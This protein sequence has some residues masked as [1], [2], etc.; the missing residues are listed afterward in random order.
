[1][2]VQDYNMTKVLS[3]KC[4][5]PDETGDI[6]QAKCDFNTLYNIQM[7]IELYN[8]CS[9]LFHHVRNSS[10]E[11]ILE[12][13][14]QRAA[15]KGA[16]TE[17]ETKGVNAGLSVL[18]MTD[19]PSGVIFERD[20]CDFMNNFYVD[21]SCRA[22]TNIEEIHKQTQE[23]KELLMQ[24]SAL[25]E[26]KELSSVWRDGIDRLV[27]NNYNNYDN[28]IMSKHKQLETEAENQ[29]WESLNRALSERKFGTSR[30]KS[31]TTLGFGM[32]QRNNG[33]DG[34]NEPV[35]GE[36]IYDESNRR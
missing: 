22:F 4:S 20:N 15:G 5:I 9:I 31:M 12:K 34:E 29:E 23:N 13:N 8:Y 3:R 21:I 28:Q 36:S 14:K 26:L 19:Q 6:K 27:D 7:D 18:L 16:Q 10:L 2:K 33:E 24:N 11:N 30:Q 17:I 35:M 32:S 25:K 1:M